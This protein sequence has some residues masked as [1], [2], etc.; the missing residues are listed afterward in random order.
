MKSGGRKGDAN[1]GVRGANDRKKIHKARRYN[2][3][4]PLNFPQM[5]D[6]GNAFSPVLAGCRSKRDL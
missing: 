4:R 1:P 3:L 5:G 6:L 2:H